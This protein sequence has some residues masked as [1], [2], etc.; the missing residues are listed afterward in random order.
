[1]AVVEAEVEGVIDSIFARPWV[2]L[3]LSMTICPLGKVRVP[4]RNRRLNQLTMVR[5]RRTH[6]KNSYP[7]IHFPTSE[8][9]GER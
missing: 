2:G 5:N 9:V 7:I 1:M 8:R 4:G 6:G 3:P